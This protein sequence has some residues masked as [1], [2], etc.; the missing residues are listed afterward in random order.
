[1]T[2]AHQDAADAILNGLD[3]DER[4]AAH[5]DDQPQREESWDEPVPLAVR[6]LQ[7]A[8]PTDAMPGWLAEHVAAVA[9]FTQTP[10]D[11]AGCIGLAS[12]ATAAGGRAVVEV[13]KD[14]VEPV[15]LFTVVA[16]PPGS[17]KSAVFGAMTDPLYA[18]ERQL[19]DQVHGQRIQAELTR[20][21]AARV[22]EHA[23]NAAASA[24]PS[25]RD[26]KLAEAHS[27]ALAAD[28]VDIPS[29]PKLIVED[30]TPETAAT[31]LAEQGGRLAVL[32]DEGGILGVLTGSRY[33]SEP[34]LDLFLKGHSAN[35]PFR[36]D[37]KG[38]DP[39]QIDRPTLTLGLALQPDV[40]LHLA[41]I[42]G[43][44][45]RGLLARILYS[46][47]ENTVG[48][49]KIDPP[50]IPADVAETYD[51]NMRGLV[52]SL[53]EWT[54][55]AVL[56]LT[57]DALKATYGLLAEIEPRLH[58]ESGDLGHIAD[59]G[60]K[61]AGA[62][63]RIAGLLHL[64]AHL[65][66]GWGR[67]I[68]SDTVAN[69]IRIGHY[70]LAHALAVFDHVDADPV[71]ADAR[72]V[73]D[74][75]KR[76]GAAEFTRRDLHRAM[77]SRFP[78]TGDLDPALTRLIEHGHIRPTST[79]TKP[80]RGRPSMTYQVHP[81]HRDEMTEVTKGGAERVSV[82][83]VIS[84]QAIAGPHGSDPRPDTD[85]KGGQA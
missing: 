11:L 7:P 43:A 53:A 40:L 8:F 46:L 28:A 32:S 17:R 68:D 22:A 26:G 10:A 74:W 4:I 35:R 16:M 2:G 42:P 67:P 48:R 47:P 20:K 6:R 82:T 30:I 72:H 18:A 73:L 45:G 81:H 15:N 38:R 12:L 58:P 66:D 49:R 70:Y 63:I 55:P 34:N 71:T 41:R 69:A 29:V 64:A 65:H 24:D 44:R 52:A 27:A 21:V 13:R 51:A 14:W 59:W 84:S 76:H 80:Q 1:M 57:P 31:L 56:P 33:S 37:R 39:E 79:T 83:S 77:Q 60:S 75:I 62:T 9:E 3:A 19:A 78:K 54:D 5:H 85:T 23:A 36:V 61:F 50:A 25:K